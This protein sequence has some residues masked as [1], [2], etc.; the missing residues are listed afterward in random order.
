[1]IKN[2]FNDVY[3]I[4]YDLFGIVSNIK[5]YKLAWILNKIFSIDLIK[6]DDLIIT[7]HNQKI[8]QISNYF[9]KTDEFITRLLKNKLINKGSYNNEKFLI[10]KLSNF[11][12]FLQVYNHS[13][14]F[15]KKEIINKNYPFV[16]QKLNNQY[17]LL[18]KLRDQI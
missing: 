10:N 5:E 12:Y 3:D 4:N 8:F 17:V 7:K 2:D 11:D 9:N 14:E 1:M 16:Q 6:F 13:N 18:H 15:N